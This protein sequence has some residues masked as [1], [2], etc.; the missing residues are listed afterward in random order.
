MSTAIAPIGM[1]DLNVIAGEP[2]ILD[3]RIG[4]RLGYERPRVVRELIE[5]N[6]EE[7]ETYGALAPRRTAQIIG[8]GRVQEV[9]EYFLNEAQ[10]LLVCMFS[11]T[12]AAASIRKEVIRVYIAY[13]RG[14]L[15]PVPSD[16]FERMANRQDVI[17][18]TVAFHVETKSPEFT[19]SLAHL[20]T[21]G[22]GNRRLPPWWG[23]VEVRRAMISLHRQAG[24][25]DV[26]GALMERFGPLRTPSRSAIGRFWTALDRAR[27]GSRRQDGGLS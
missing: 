17:R 19:E 12:P 25:D 21:E 7:L 10:T 26:R 23:D 2:R 3:I 15:T 20:L 1:A 27:G 6:R 9:D 8:K 11:K 18:R 13:R 22:R 14:Q 24:L 5:R 4:E 16:P